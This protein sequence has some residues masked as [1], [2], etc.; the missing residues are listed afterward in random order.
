MKMIIVF[1]GGGQ[2]RVDIEDV[3]TKRSVVTNELTGI[4]WA[5][6]GDWTSKLHTVEIDQIAAVVIEREAC[7]VPGE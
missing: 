3:T 7:D 6:P 4:D 1:K 2:I 5:T